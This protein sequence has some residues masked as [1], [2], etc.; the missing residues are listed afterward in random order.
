MTK[1]EL[2]DYALT[3][4][5]TLNVSMTKAEM[6]DDYNKSLGIV[7]DAPVVV[8][9]SD[10]QEVTP[11][12][13]PEVTV[14]APP[15]ADTLFAEAVARNAEEERIMSLP[16]EE[17]VE[18]VQ[19]TIEEAIGILRYAVS[20]GK[21]GQRFSQEDKMLLLIDKIEESIQY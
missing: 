4:W 12:V 5:V 18:L 11:E 21:K 17:Q 16:V 6:I 10:V 15:S 19:W 20:R 9:S 8:A 13:T 1:Q 2:A 3:L 14:D 7:V